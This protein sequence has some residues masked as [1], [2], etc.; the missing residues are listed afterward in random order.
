VSVVIL[1]LDHIN[2]NGNELWINGGRRTALMDVAMAGITLQT[3]SNRFQ[4]ALTSVK[5][6]G[7]TFAVANTTCN[8][9]ST[10]CF[11]AF[12]LVPLWWQYIGNTILNPKLCLPKKTHVP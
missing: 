2:F 6:S 7:L 3:T 12:P 4:E 10:Y 11:Y 8:N 1:S 5:Y 9:I